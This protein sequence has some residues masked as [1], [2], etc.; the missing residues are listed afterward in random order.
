M[1]SVLILFISYLINKNFL[2]NRRNLIVLSSS[3]NLPFNNLS[4][5]YNLPYNSQESDKTIIH[6]NKIDK[7]TFL[8]P[9]TDESCYY[10]IE[11]IEN[12]KNN[13]CDIIKLNIQSAGGSLLPAFGVVDLIRTSEIPIHTYINGY[14]ASAASLIS[15]SGHKRLMGKNGLMLIHSL[16]TS[17]EGGTYLNIKDNSDNADTF[18]NLLKDIYLLNSNIDEKYLNYLLSHDL[19]LNSSTCL[20]NK[21]ID[22]IL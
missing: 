7:I 6:T 13:K 21:L 3:L 22:Q 8:G 4:L 10:L 15:V 20:Q 18:M 2:V 12:L 9:I 17:S 11:S 5:E 14:V 19:W 1:F 16:R